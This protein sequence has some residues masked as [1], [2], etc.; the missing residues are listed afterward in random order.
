[1]EVLVVGIVWYGVFIFSLTCHESAHSYA[2]MKLG[3]L[4]A[5]HNGQVTLNPLP[6][7]RR[8][9][10]GT[11][12]VPVISYFMNGWMLGWASAPYD[13]IWASR[14]PKRSAVMSLA[15][16]SANLAIVIVCALLIRAGIYFG[17]FTAPSLVT[18]TEVTSANTSGI[19]AGIAFVLSILFN[20]NLILFSF[21]LIPLPPL[22]G[23]GILPLFMNEER[24]LR[25]QAIM[26]NPQFSFIGLFIAWRI[27]DYLFDP[28][29]RVALNMLYFGTASY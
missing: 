29:Q 6:H 20:L 23:S 11:I 19:F 26:Q 13:P 22:D 28:I 21:N 18:M 4:T 16:P 24:A 15:G 2:A 17:V 12:I 1:M 5:Y 7:I 9:P 8:E 10:L 25:I 27:F 14:Y 3:D